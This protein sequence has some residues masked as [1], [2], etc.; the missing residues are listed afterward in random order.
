MCVLC[1]LC[2]D[3]VIS[4]PTLRGHAHRRTVTHIHGMPHMFPQLFEKDALY[5]VGAAPYEA[6]HACN[7]EAVV[8]RGK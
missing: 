1:V 5:E 4:G 7:K 3:L 8:C 6:C 2:S